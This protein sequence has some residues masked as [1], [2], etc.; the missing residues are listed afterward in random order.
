MGGVE[1][2]WWVMWF[3][4]MWCGVALGVWCGVACGVVWCDVV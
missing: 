3:G 4:V 2:F 1:V